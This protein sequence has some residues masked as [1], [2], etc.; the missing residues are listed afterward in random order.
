MSAFFGLGKDIGDTLMKLIFYQ[1]MMEVMAKL[2]VLLFWQK[3]DG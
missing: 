3:N 2:A 1:G